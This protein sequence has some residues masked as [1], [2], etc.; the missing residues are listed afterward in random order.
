M[1]RPSWDEYFMSV[2]DSI[3]LRATCD[4]GKS[5]TIIVQDKR[6]IAAGYVGS[7]IGFPHCDDIGHEL[8]VV[9]VSTVIN[10]DKEGMMILHTKTRSTHCFR[11][12]HAEINAI[13]NAARHGASTVGSTMYCTMVP[14]RVCAFAIIQCGIAK[15]V[16]KYPYQSMEDTIM[17]FE[18]ASVK[19]VVN[20]EDLAYN[21]IHAR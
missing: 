21:P 18:L 13:C 7:P 15:V 5:G 1:P 3:A 8:Y 10:E 4:R 14:C 20:K 19:L 9:D 6:I 16:A 11:T 2:V 17:A 12:V